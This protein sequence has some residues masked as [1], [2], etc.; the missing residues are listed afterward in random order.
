MIP[1]LRPGDPFPSPDTA[2]ADPNGLLAAGLELHPARLLDAYRQGIFPWFSEGGPVLWWSPAP[3]MV[4]FTRELRVTRS[5]A[6]TLANRRYSIT[7]DTD[8]P[9]VMRECAAPTPAR[10]GTWITEQVVEAYTGLHRL[11]HAHSV[12]TRIDGELVGGLYGVMLGRM[13]FGESMF[14]RAS[15]ASKL[16]FVHLVRRLAAAGVE[17]IDCQMKTRHLE[18]LGGREISREA[19]M[20]RLTPAVDTPAP[21]ALWNWRHDNEP[22]R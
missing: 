22:S 14:A 6:K 12:E 2:L 15:D 13:F 17:M 16:A 18:S 19:F 3:R 9:R 10:P 8:F 4:L 7:V 20:A 21:A 5:L 11:G 1:W